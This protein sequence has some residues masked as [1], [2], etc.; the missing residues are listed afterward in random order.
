MTNPRQMQLCRCLPRDG[1]AVEDPRVSPRMSA[2]PF[3]RASSRTRLKPLPLRVL[4]RLR[5]HARDPRARERRRTLAV[6][7]LQERADQRCV[8]S[9]KG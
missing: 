3:S 6:R 4:T 7:D 5:Q 1:R 9:Y 2:V 8:L